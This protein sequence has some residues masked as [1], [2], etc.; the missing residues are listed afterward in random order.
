MKLRTYQQEAVDAVFKEWKDH[1]STLV[2]MPT[3]TGKTQMFTEVVRRQPKRSLVVA[4]REELIFQARNRIYEA[5]GQAPELEMAEYVASSTDLYGNNRVVIATVQTLNSGAGEGR[6]S[7]FDPDDFSLVVCDEAHHITAKTYLN[8]MEYFKQNKDCKILGVT[9][10]PDRADE[11]ALGRVFDSVAYNYEIVDAINDGYLVPVVTNT[12]HVEGLDFSS[13]RTTAGD[14]NGADLAA[15]MEYEETLHRMAHPT[16]EIVGKK[17]A[18]VFCASVAHAERFCEILNRHEAGCANWVCGETPKDDR[19]RILADYAA[20]KFRFLCNV[21]VLT[22]GYDSPDTDCVVIC[23][24]TK[25]RSLYA[26]MVGR[27]M[28]PLPG[29]ID[30]D[31]GELL[32]GPDQRKAAIA[33]SSK[34]CMTIIDFTGNSGRHKLITAADILGGKYPD[35]IVEKVQQRLQK[36]KGEVNILEALREEAEKKKKERE[37]FRRREEARRAKLKVKANY[38]IV[39]MDAFDI[40]GITPPRAYGWDTNR[41]PTDKMVALLE[42][43]GI[44]TKDM[45]FA[46]ARALIVEITGRWDK[47]QCSLKQARILQ[48]HGYATDVSRQEASK[49]LDE[50]FK[51]RASSAP[52]MASIRRF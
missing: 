10:T 22:E 11:E 4:H 52:A 38:T 24:P 31:L 6:M 20:K 43:Q 29:L 45:N 19:R 39:P 42:K 40:F 36:A 33:G 47:G 51:G 41:R 34:A 3:G 17:K 46:Q 2:V 14:L 5:T 35:E 50:I 18:L 26:Q 48:K 15:I 25:S 27:A 30:V 37:E 44:Q 9:A 1:T 7:S 13:I 23:R 12:V 8:V 28:R 21:G 16:F 49:L 32:W